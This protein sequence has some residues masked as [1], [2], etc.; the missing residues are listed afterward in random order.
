[1]KKL[2]SIVVSFML[3]L[4]VALVAQEDK[5]AQPE[6]GGPEKRVEEHKEV[7]K[8][9]KHPRKE[10][11]HAK[12]QSNKKKHHAKKHKENKKEHQK[13]HEVKE[14]NVKENNDDVK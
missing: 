11:K 6:Q 5:A 10:K 1:M 4:P 7:K 9:K 8:D 2:L 14:D 13:K 3:A 12:K